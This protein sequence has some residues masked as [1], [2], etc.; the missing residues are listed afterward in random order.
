MSFSKTINSTTLKSVRNTFVQLLRA[1]VKRKHLFLI[2]NG[3]LLATIFYFYSEDR[4]EKKLFL[5]LANHV[6]ATTTVTDKDSL[7]LRSLNL[8]H[9]LGKQRVDA[10]GNQDLNSL[11]SFIHPVTLDLMTVRGSCGSYCMVLSRILTEL[12]ISNRIIQMKVHGEYGGH[13]VVEAEASRGKWVV[14]DPSYNVS[15]KKQDGTL[16][17]FKEVG[18]DWQY[19]SKQVPADYNMD[20][21]YEGAQYTNWKKI[22]LVM[23]ALKSVLSWTMGQEKANTI[24]L[25][26]I[27]LRKYHIIFLVTSGLYLLMLTTVFAKYV[28]RNRVNAAVSAQLRAINHGHIG[29]ASPAV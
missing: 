20:Y 16:A 1:A 24:S 6:H 2:L 22:P 10:F 3:F 23:P 26:T 27:F 4:Y 9:E 12:K 18:G 17:D 21:A 7:I 19:F 14:L 25:R 15:Y 8:T 13:I 11:K 29:S 28:R 5:A